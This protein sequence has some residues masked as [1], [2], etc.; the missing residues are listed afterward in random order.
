V[1][2]ETSVEAK[3]GF[4]VVSGLGQGGPADSLAQQCTHVI[5]HYVNY[6]YQTRGVPFALLRFARE[7]RGQLRGQW[8]TTFHELYAWGPPWK[9]EF[10]LRPLQVKIA[11]D[12]P[13]GR[14]FRQ[15]RRRREGDPPARCSEAHSAGARHVEFW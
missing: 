13:L 1:N 12:R 2:L 14:L 5:L 10:W 6:G 11:R 9:S 15:Q 7:L 4:R 8:V 3:D